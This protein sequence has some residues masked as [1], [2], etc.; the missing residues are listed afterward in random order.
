MNDNVK[1]ILI[2]VALIAINVALF[3]A[4]VWL[5]ANIVKGVFG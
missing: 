1:I 4:L 5:G 2:S 3:A